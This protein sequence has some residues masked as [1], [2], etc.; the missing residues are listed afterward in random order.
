MVTEDFPARF[1]RLCKEANLPD[2]QIPLAKE[3]QVS[4]AFIAQVRGGKKMLSIDTAIRWSDKLNCTVEYLLKGKESARDLSPG[5]IEI[6]HLYERCS[7]KYREF[8]MQ[9]ARMV[10]RESANEESI[11]AETE[12]T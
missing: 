9:N 1:K 5:A 4:G 10:A 12:V 6:A 3:L 11:D 2:K 8:M 7:G